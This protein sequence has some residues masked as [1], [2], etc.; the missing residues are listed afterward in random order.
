MEPVVRAAFLLL[1]GTIASACVVSVDS[2]GVVVR[3]VKQFPVDGVPELHLSTFDGAISL[4]SWD[5]PQVLVEIEKRGPAREVVDALVVETSRRGNRIEIEVKRPR[6]EG[7]GPLGFRV[8]TTARLTVSTPRRSNVVAR[9]GDGAIHLERLEGR[10]DLRTGDGAIRA[11]DLSGELVLHTGDGA[12]T[13]DRAD[14]RLRLET[15]DGGVSVTGQLTAVQMHTGDGSIVYRADP[16]VVMSDDWDIST[17]DGS[18]SLYLPED[19]GAELDAHTG[20]GAIRTELALAAAGSPE[21]RRRTL[22]GRLGTGG[23][24][25]RVRTG[26][27]SITLNAR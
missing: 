10:I 4:Q 7:F 6:A 18:V 19:F 11:S 25:L 15:G 17:G 21:G 2:Q 22:R 20:D 12:I 3:D 26:D 16:G 5:K 8:A 23:R 13:V 14:G 24:L 27:G 1:A 9:T